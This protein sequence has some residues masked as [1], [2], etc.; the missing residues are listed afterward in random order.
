MEVQRAVRERD[1]QCTFVDG[2]GRWRSEKRFLTIEHVEPF[3]MNAP[4]TVEN[5]C[6]LCSSHNADRARQAFGQAH[7]ARKVAEARARR[8]APAAP[9]ERDAFEKVQSALVHSGFKQTQARRALEEVRRRGVEA[10]PEPLLRAALAV[11]VP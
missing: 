8:R 3:A 2:E 10:R 9:P 6:L 7:V 5:C 11:L 4:T 1:D